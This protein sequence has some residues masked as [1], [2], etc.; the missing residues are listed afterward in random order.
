MVCDLFMQSECGA[1]HVWV[2]KMWC[3]ARFF[4]FFL[5]GSAVDTVNDKNMVRH[6][7]MSLQCGAWHVWVTKMLCVIHFFFLFD[8]KLSRRY[9]Q[10]VQI[11]KIYVQFKDFNSKIFVTRMWCVTHLCH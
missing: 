7:F 11:A 2:T 8:E 6:S 4:H 3:V 1:W 9:Y 10:L 5:R